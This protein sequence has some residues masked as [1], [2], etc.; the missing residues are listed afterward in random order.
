MWN[1]CRHGGVEKLV[2]EREDIGCEGLDE[3]GQE[4]GGMEGVERDMDG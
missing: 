2:E 1:F 4:L 3:G